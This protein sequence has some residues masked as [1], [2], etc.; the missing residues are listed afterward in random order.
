[1]TPFRT[2]RAA[3]VRFA[4]LFRSFPQDREFEDELESHLQMLIDDNLRSG[5]TADEARRQA[6]VRLGGVESIKETYRDRRSIPLLET[7]W[8]DVRYATR[9]L[10]KNPAAS[11]IGIFVMAI[12]IG[13]NTAV[14]SVVHAVLLNPLPYPSAERLVTLTYIATGGA[15]TGDRARQVSAPDFRDW[16]KA[17]TSFDAMAY[18]AGGRGSVIAG[19]VAE[20]A[21]VMR[22]SEEFFRVLAVEPRSG[23]AFTSDE[24]RTGRVALIS[25]RYAREHF[26]DPAHAI[27]RTL[28]IGR[29]AYP[30]VGVLPDSFDFPADTDVWIP[31]VDTAN[32]QRRGNNFRA[33]ARL[34]LGSTLDQ[35]QA[36]MTTISARLEEQYPDTN[37]NIRVLVTPMHREM[38]G[39]VRAML[40]LLLAAVA[41]VLLIACATM[42]TLLLARATT[43]ASEIAVREALGAS[44]TRI[45]QQLLVEASV[46]ALLA[47]ALG[48]LFAIAGTRALV[49]LSPAD[50]PR[51]D[52]VSVN[53]AVLTFTVVISCVVGLLFGLP[54]AVQAARL[55]V[56]EPLR[57]NS[58]R[59]TDG[60]GGRMR[61]ALVVLELAISVVLVATGALL[62]RSLIALQNAPVGFEPANVL[63][64]ETTRPPRAQDWSDSRAFFQGLLAD[65]SRMPGVITAGAMMGPP[66]RVGSESGYWIDRMPKES[67]FTSARPAVINVVTPDAF[68]ALAIPVQQGRDF[69]EGDTMTA[70]KVVIVNSALAR[71]AFPGT[72]PLGRIIV[73]G[74]DSDEPMSIIGVVGDMRQYGPSQPPQP[75]IYLPYQQHFYNGA[76][77]CIL[78]KTATD[79]SALGPSIQRQAHERSPDASVRVTTMDALLSQNIATPRFRAWLLSLFAV[80]A[81]CL[82]MAGVYG[83]MAYA[84]GQRSKEIGIRMALGANTGRVLSLMLGRGLK[85]TAIGLALGAAGA[86]FATRFVSGMLFEVQPHDVAT[87]AGVVAGLGLLSLLATYVPARRATTI[88][89]LLVLRQ[90]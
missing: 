46:Q 40:Y 43:R 41:L 50:V 5:M 73:A 78:V 62:V 64:M 85:L 83:V 45:V 56:G 66:G 86:W 22:V 34:R 61:D 89:P 51:L 87:Y 82:A 48:V 53:A 37:R 23:R 84:V 26:G 67:P 65:I 24:S 32:Q 30:I 42:A 79:A 15:A 47:G 33:I 63:M 55:A 39:D 25:E 36:E 29:T 18:F 13:A 16:Q 59:I 19:S 6:L 77:L 10:R 75:E 3:L 58:A 21:V 69:R 70:P 2:L 11:L 74:Y 57:R 7:V 17:A 8:Q 72:D 44:R 35:A 9:T 1:M 80:V 71:A 38:V 31:I 81:V 68:A 4:G 60:P 14:F 54:P 28:R 27:G 76:T 49:A 90:E 12:G 88:D 20:Y 52:E